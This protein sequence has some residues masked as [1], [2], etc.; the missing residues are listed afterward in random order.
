MGYNIRK[1]LRETTILQCTGI[2]HFHGT[3]ST[4]KL[5]EDPSTGIENAANAQRSQVDIISK[6]NHIWS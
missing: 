5:E 3:K 4:S 2:K 1:Q 6:K